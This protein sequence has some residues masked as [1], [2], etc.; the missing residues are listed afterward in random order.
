MADD[1][2]KVGKQDRDRVNVNEPYE[3]A[4]WAKKL[5]VSAD[6]IRSAVTKVGPMAKDVEKEVKKT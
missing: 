4:D 3:L 1:K 5:G 6:R 2:D